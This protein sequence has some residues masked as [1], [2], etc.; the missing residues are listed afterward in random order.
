MEKYSEEQLAE[1]KEAFSLFDKDGDGT[2][3]P[4]ELDEILKSL[5]QKLSPSEL[6][7]MMREIDTDNSGTINFMEFL[8]LMERQLITGDKD[9]EFKEAFSLFDKDGNGLISASE[10]KAVM[11]N[12]GESMNDT[13]I[14]QMIK[15]VDIDGDGQINYI[16]FVKMLKE[17]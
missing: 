8:V 13:E 7:E 4:V 14:E 2:I 10:L 12:V 1:F 6:S 17:K 5:G 11:K 15:E 9:R 3:S 16:E